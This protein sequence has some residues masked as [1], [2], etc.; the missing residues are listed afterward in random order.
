MI[1]VRRS[2]LRLHAELALSRIGAAGTVVLCLGAAA[3]VSWIWAVPYTKQLAN[4]SAI[5]LVQAKRMTQE[6]NIAPPPAPR[7]V[8]QDRLKAFYEALGEQ[9]YAEQ[10]VKTLFAAA[11]KSG[12]TLNQAEYRYGFDKNGD[13]A[14]YQAILPVKGSYRAIRTFCEQVLVSVPFASLDEIN[15]KRE[16]IGSPNLEARLRF[17]IYLGAR[18][19]KPVEVVEPLQEERRS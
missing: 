6:A 11:A 13:F 9:G 1:T 14:T 12:L 4:D 18:A 10:Q 17:T 7:A 19:P 3:L 8:D 15:F 16:S 2:D 5:R